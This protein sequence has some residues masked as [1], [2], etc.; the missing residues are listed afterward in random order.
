MNK[1]GFSDEF[2]KEYFK[3]LEK[4]KYKSEPDIETVF[5]ELD[6]LKNCMGKNSL[7]FSFVTKFMC[8]LD[9]SIP[10]YDIEVCRV[11]SFTQPN[12]PDS[13]ALYNLLN[14]LEI[15]RDTYNE[16]VDGDLIPKTMKLFDKKFNEYDLP[17]IKKFDFIFW[18]CGNLDIFNKQLERNQFQNN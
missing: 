13:S 17:M 7:M 4:Y 14:Y 3:L 1:V 15:I 11:F 16:I 9:D 2:I 6:R 10:I 5:T 8:T 12:N 18:S